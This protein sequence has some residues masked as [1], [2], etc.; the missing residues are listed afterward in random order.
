MSTLGLVKAPLPMKNVVHTVK[1]AINTMLMLIMI[2]GEKSIRNSPYIKSKFKRKIVQN[3]KSV[4]T[5]V[6]FVENFI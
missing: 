1:Y 4:M 6:W 5:L 3:L 2:K